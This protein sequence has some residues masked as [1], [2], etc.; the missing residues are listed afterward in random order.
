MS[1]KSHGQI[2]RSQAIMTFG[3]GAFIDLP[4]HSAII[5]GLDTWPAESE[6]EQVIEPRLSAKL[7]FMTGVQSPRLY[8]PPAED[9]MPWESPKGITAWR[10]PEWFLVQQSE[11]GRDDPGGGTDSNES[12]RLVHRRQLEKNRFEGRRVVPTRFVRACPKGHVSDL[13]WMSFAHRGQDSCR[14]RG[15]WID[16]KGTGGDLNDFRVRCDCGAGRPLGEATD[17]ENLGACF[18]ERPWLG[19]DDARESCGI[20]FRLLIRTATNAYFS[21]VVTVLSLPEAQRAIDMAVEECWTM[22]E[23]VNDQGALAVLRSNIPQ[24]RTKMETFSDD[25]IFDAVERK[26]AGGPGERSPKAA[27]VEAILAAPTGFGDDVPIDQDFHVRRLPDSMWRQSSL[28]DPIEAVIQLHRL[29]AVS[30]MTGFTRLEPTTPDIHGDYPGDVK[31][32]QIAMEPSWF[33]AMENRGEGLFVQVRAA[34]IEQ[35]RNRPGVQ[36]RLAALHQGQERWNERRNKG[37][38]FCG[39]E[40]VLLH[41]LSHL[42]LDALAMTCGYPASAIRERVY[43]DKDTGSFGI[44]LYTGSPDAEGTLGGLVQQARSFELHLKKALMAASLCSN[45]P[46]C[47]QHDCG[48][49]MEERWLHGA[50]CHGCAFVAETSCEMRNEYLDRSLVVPILGFGEA[51]L[52]PRVD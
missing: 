8:A 32:A 7:Q 33:P 21:Q 18:G 31:A 4:D 16:E 29:R 2:R 3:P 26:R 51:A 30:A 22:L 9:V 52:F 41:T 47:A 10:F 1:K 35:W 6:L 36:S 37:R 39:G 40:Y 5:G 25:E 45:D 27:E 43:V 23:G 42:L 15:L 28:S 17:G 49:S 12:R 20:P 44:L 19:G 38:D 13:N 11:S 46:I 50:A 48:E 24:L 14:G 34:A